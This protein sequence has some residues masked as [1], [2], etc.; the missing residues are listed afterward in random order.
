MGARQRRWY[1]H[2][3]EE[4]TGLTRGVDVRGALA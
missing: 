1:R 3:K 4:M 2:N